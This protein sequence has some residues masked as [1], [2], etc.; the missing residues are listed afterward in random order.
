ML[1]T[2]AELGVADLVKLL[3]DNGANVNCQQGGRGTALHYAAKCGKD[4]C[5]DVLIKAKAN[6]NIKVN[7]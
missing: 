7:K 5:V 2:A 3:V 4:A 6:L 1:K